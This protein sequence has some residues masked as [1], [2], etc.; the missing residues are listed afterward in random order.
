MSRLPRPG[1]DDNVWGNLLNDFLQVEHNIDGTLRKSAAITQAAAN[2]AQA[3][4][5]ANSASSTAAAAQNAVS[6]KLNASQK[7]V[8]G[9]VAA[10]DGNGLLSVNTIP[11]LSSLYLALGTGVTIAS[12]DGSNQPWKLIALQDGTVKAV[13]QNVTAPA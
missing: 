10:L 13:P 3:L 1:A 5:T 12:A 9:G 8:A 11:D 4:T 6:G 7:G 2:A